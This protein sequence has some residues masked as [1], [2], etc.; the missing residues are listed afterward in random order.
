[1]VIGNL[2]PYLLLCVHKH[3][4]AHLDAFKSASRVSKPG[5]LTSEVMSLDEFRE[6]SQS[7]VAVFGEVRRLGKK[8]TVCDATCLEP[9]LVVKGGVSTKS[10]KGVVDG[11]IVTDRGLA[12][13]ILEYG[14]WRS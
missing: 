5:F 4:R 10:S 1:M 14:D 11:S 12:N 3:R 2:T 8:L 13:V 7:Q 9:R 6:I